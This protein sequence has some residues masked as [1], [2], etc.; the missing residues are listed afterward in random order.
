MS[1]SDGEVRVKINFDTSNA[2]K[3]VASLERE[4]GK[5]EKKQLPLINQF[6]A[7]RAQITQT[8]RKLI[9]TKEA[10]STGKIDKV[11]AF[12][13]TKEGEENLKRLKTEAE[14][15]LNKIEVLDNQI[16]P[17]KEKI[18]SI[19]FTGTP[20]NSLADSAAAAKQQL[21]QAAAAAGKI[22]PAVDKADKKAM[23]LGKSV[24]QPKKSFAS[25]FS[26]LKERANSSFGSLEKTTSRF[27]KRIGNTIMSAFV[28]SVLYKGLSQ[29]KQQLAGALQTN[30]QFA[31]SLAIIKGNLATA[32][33]PILQ[34]VMPIINAFMQKIIQ[35][36][37]YIAAFI[38]LLLGKSTSA[39][40]AAAKAM[41]QSINATKSGA[42]GSTAAEKE[43]TAAI[44]EK[45]R[46]VKAL[47]RENKALTKEYN[48][49]KK[50][51]EAQ[52]NVLEKQIKSL[53]NQKDALQRVEKAHNRAAAAQR[54]SIQASIDALQ[55]Q[56]SAL[57]K[58]QA[59]I[60]K[61]QEEAQKQVNAQK[62]AIDAQVKALQKRIKALQKEKKAAEDAKKANQR[63]TT[64][65]DEL[66]TIGGP[67][68]AD[69]YD[70]EIEQ[71]QEQIEDL[72]E[73]KE[74]IEDVDYSDRLEALDAENEKLQEQID[75]LNEQKDAIK[76]ADY[77]A[78]LQ[79]YDDRISSIR[80]KIDALKDSVKENPL[81]EKNEEA[82]E[83]L[84]EQ[85]DKL[86]EQKDALAENAGA[87]DNLGMKFSDVL[88]NMQKKLEESPIGKWL[89]EN[90]E[91]IKQFVI[92]AGTFAGVILLFVK[93]KDIIIVLGKV[94]ATVFSGPAGIVA[95]WA[96]AIAA[97]TVWAGNGEECIANL[98]NALGYFLDFFENVFAGDWEAAID[99]LKNAIKSLLNVYVL[100]WES[101][102]KAGATAINWV[103]EK[104]NSLLAK[105][106]DSIKEK[107]GGAQINWR[108]NVDVDFSQF[109]Q[110]VPALAQGAVLPPNKPFLA[111]V[112]DQRQGTNIEAPLSTIEEAVRNV[113]AEQGNNN[114]VINANGSLG[115]LI[116]LLKLQIDKESNRSTAF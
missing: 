43:L 28:F 23:S 62:A 100:I 27:S 58:Q 83:V 98:K 109:M 52:T 57:S 40:A 32:F 59:Q 78:A 70:T 63:Y 10:L 90:G 18:E 8:E 19:K 61:Q 76:D 50:A 89:S 86:Q 16:L 49:Q 30:T 84:Q 54:E 38:N 103:I 41:Q 113:L 31:N 107:F 95:I 64:S 25:L 47:Q 82:I 81:I 53:E 101:I 24:E 105:L 14:D 69:P 20:D 94:V 48:Q 22:A 21:E 102:V 73:R 65:F 15:F 11:Q 112:G 46:Q 80:E 72:Q 93:L 26:S 92:I 6:E 111:W 60:R 39:S 45:Q 56:Q 104:V 36:T 75:M 79:G 42:S 44:K 71:L 7:L 55:K 1:N 99:S 37:A 91:K 3:E 5:L 12:M 74:L 13:D 33:Q 87:A 68:E 2:A 88:T 106:P 17:L 116:R 97:I 9:E 108:A 85:I 110:N 114:F 4:V 29:L 35:I 77:S 115:P 66:S 34:T 51:V 67:E 96:A